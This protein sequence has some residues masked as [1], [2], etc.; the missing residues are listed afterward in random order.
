MSSHTLRVEGSVT[1]PNGDG[2]KC[3][4]S[5]LLGG[6]KG[7]GDNGG[8]NNKAGCEIVRD[9]GNKNNGFNG[10]VGLTYIKLF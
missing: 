8:G 1:G 10:S 4:S 3:H 9:N 6:N 5:N 7:G 2:V